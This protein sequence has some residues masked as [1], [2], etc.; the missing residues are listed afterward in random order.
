MKYI[1]VCSGIGSELAAFP[2]YWEP[3]AVSEIAAF[4]SAVLTHHYPT[5]PNLGDMTKIDWRRYRGTIDLISGGTPCQGFSVAGRGEGLDDSR[6]G[7]ALGY[8]RAIDESRPRWVVWENVCGLL[9]KRNWA[10]FRTFGNALAELGYCFAWRVLD[11]QFFG[12]P[13]QRRRVFIVGYRGK[14]WRPAAATLLESPAL[15]GLNQTR[16]KPGPEIVSGVVGGA[17]IHTRRIAPTIRAAH[18]M[19]PEHAGIPWVI[20]TKKSP[21]LL[22]KFDGSPSF[23][24]YPWVITL[25]K[26]PCL[27]AH[28]QS[29]QN[30]S[31]P[32]VIEGQKVKGC[33]IRDLTPEEREECFGFPRGYTAITYRGKPAR[34]SPRNTALGNSIAVPVLSWIARRMDLVHKLIEEKK[35]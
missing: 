25:E 5:V 1:S 11:A 14:D 6:S 32:F 13:Q 18:G 7:L 35:L 12:V 4:P 10:D 20:T 22:A 15:Q 31:E 16:Q 30:E 2:G 3:V 24:S 34:D 19:P 23:C 27:T 33:K 8:L 26:A 9:T 29:R 28:H 21:A 17:E